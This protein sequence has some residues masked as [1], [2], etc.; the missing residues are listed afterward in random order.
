MGLGTGQ[1]QQKRESVSGMQIRRNDA[2][3]SMESKQ[4]GKHERNVQRHGGESEMIK[5]VL[6][7]NSR[8]RR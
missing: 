1:T 7:P 3:C 4:K 6:N 2:E 8:S 5:H